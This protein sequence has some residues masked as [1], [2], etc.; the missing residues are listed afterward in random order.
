MILNTKGVYSITQL[1]VQRDHAPSKAAQRLQFQVFMIPL[2]LSSAM[3]RFCPQ[4]DYPTTSQYLPIATDTMH[5][6]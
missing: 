4:A 3:L 2:T 5:F 6:F 1:N